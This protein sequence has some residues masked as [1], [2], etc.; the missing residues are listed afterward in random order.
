MKKYVVSIFVL[1]A[2]A[3]CS[4]KTVKSEPVENDPAAAISE[5][6]ISNAGKMDHMT[7]AVVY[8]TD[9]DGQESEEGKV[10]SER[11][12]T[13]LAANGRIKVVERT[14][15]NQV[16][17]EQ[18]LG[19]TGLTEESDNSVGKLLSADGIV[20]G[21]I[22]EKNEDQEI[23]ARLVGVKSGE[24][25]AAI[26]LKKTRVSQG[27]LTSE[28]KNRL[29]QEIRAR[30]EMKNKDPKRYEVNQKVKAEMTSLKEK[31]PAKFRRTLYLVQQLERFRVNR[32]GIYLL[33]TEPDDSQQLQQLKKN[34]PD[35]FTRINDGRRGVAFILQNAPSFREKIV[36]DRVEAFQRFKN[37]K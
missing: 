23:S 36:F 8:F 32:P 25:L 13:M 7:V 21:T 35:E 24:I 17:D 30:Q 20:S 27:G 31:N 14:K 26:I 37:R 5:T 15:L 29:D 16:L 28:Q 4:G 10:L 1:L 33:L 18:K 11:I 12:V 9:I 34:K 3:A 2:I 6:I 22:M 19:L